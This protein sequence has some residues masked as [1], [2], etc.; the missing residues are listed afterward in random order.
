[1]RGWACAA[2][3]L[4]L[5]CESASAQEDG[6]GIVGSEGPVSRSTGLRFPTAPGWTLV[7]TPI[8]FRAPEKRSFASKSIVA[9]GY[10]AVDAKSGRL[11]LFLVWSLPPDARNLRHRVVLFDAAC[12]RH[13]PAQEDVGEVG[14]ADA[15]LVSGVYSIDAKLLGEEPVGYFGIERHTPN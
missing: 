7:D 6:D 12:N 14:N 4:L 3:G 2:L 10:S 1:M 11:R 8:G 15:H 13:Y 5:F 9:S